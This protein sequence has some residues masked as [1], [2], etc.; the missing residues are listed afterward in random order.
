MSLRREPPTFRRVEVRDRVLVSPRLMR[1]TLGG[2]ELDGFAIAEPAASVRLLLPER[3]GLAT[4]VWNGNEFLR[5][6]GSR[7]RIRTLTPRRMRD[8]DLDVEIVLHDDSPLTRWAESGTEGAISGPGRGFEIA[9]GRTY[10]LVGDESALPAISQLLEQLPPGTQ[11]IVEAHTPE[12]RIELP[13][14]VTWVGDMAAAVESA[15]LGDN[16]HVWAA[17]NAAT[18]QRIRRH[19]F[20]TRHIPRDRATV[21]GYWK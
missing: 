9:A 21:R 20:E 1:V 7:P 19:L 12:A 5:A 17:G 8:G 15:D 10:L 11:V 2:P 6:D 14:A 3:D 16:V 4:P 18:V 13:A